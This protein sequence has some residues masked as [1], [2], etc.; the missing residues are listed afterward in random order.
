MLYCMSEI[1]NW[2]DLSVAC[3]SRRM[4]G[5]TVSIIAN[6]VVQFASVKGS[7]EGDSG[8][9][10]ARGARSSILLAMLM[11]ERSGNEVERT[12]FWKERLRS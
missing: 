12:R 7:S 2:V 5:I 4:D 1:V 6:N 3:V 11:V 8:N 10:A 9:A